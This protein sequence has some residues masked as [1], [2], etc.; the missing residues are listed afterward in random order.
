[1]VIAR[2]RAVAAFR[3]RG[4]V[5]ATL[6]GFLGC[7]GERALIPS[8]DPFFFLALSEQDGINSG[9]SVIRAILMHSGDPSIARYV[10]A[11][12]VE[13]F[14]VGDN[15]PFAWREIA[16]PG[17]PPAS[18]Q[19]LALLTAGNYVL[20]EPTPGGRLGR[21]ALVAGAEYALRIT[22]DD[23]VVSGR[24]RIPQRVALRVHEVEGRRRVSWSPVPG[25][26]LYVVDSETEFVAVTTPDTFYVLFEEG[27]RIGLDDTSPRRLRVAALDSN[28]AKYWSDTTISRSGISSGYGVF[29]SYS[30][31]DTM[32]TPRSR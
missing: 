3:R 17:V 32:L 13:M 22:L 14:R 6:A 20:D 18:Y 4:I 21:S 7:G 31:R 8:S 11:H 2:K 19:G 27:G 26:P 12:S 16:S 9:D 10:A 24:T 29:G 28:L 15:A 25:V 5:C 1:M 30:A 23:R